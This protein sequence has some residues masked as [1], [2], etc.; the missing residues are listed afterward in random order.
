[1]LPPL[2]STKQRRSFSKAL[3]IEAPVAVSEVLVAA[4][5]WVQYLNWF[6]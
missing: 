2:R 5:M 3:V 4:E 1:M 6:E